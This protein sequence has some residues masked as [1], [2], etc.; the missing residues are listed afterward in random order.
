MLNKLIAVFASALV[1]ASCSTAGAQSIETLHANGPYEPYAER[2]TTFGRLVGDWDL[3]VEYR[4]DDGSWLSTLGEWHFGWVLQGRAIQDVWIA[5][6]PGAPR[7]DQ[8]AIMGYGATVRAFDADEDVWR[9][10][11]LG[12]LNHN[13]TRFV[14][15]ARGDEIVMEADAEGGEP[16]QWVFYDITANGFRWRAQTSSDGGQTWTVV[17]RMTAVRRETR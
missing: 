8:G 10:N 15:R 1:F 4:Q 11:W 17:Q 9:V 16:F 3:L 5:Y 12:V 14:A 6:R 2:M 13:Y 7:G